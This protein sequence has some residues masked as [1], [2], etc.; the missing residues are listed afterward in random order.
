MVLP[1]LAREAALLITQSI[2]KFDV[3]S[4]LRQLFA[5]THL[6]DAERRISV[7]MGLS[8]GIDLLGQLIH[9]QLQLAH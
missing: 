3:P 1:Q 4:V 6:L 9:I 7:T 2:S 8:K 5:L